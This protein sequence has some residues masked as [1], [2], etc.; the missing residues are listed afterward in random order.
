MVVRIVTSLDAVALSNK[1]ISSEPAD[2]ITKSGGC[3]SIMMLTA[4]T[5]FHQMIKDHMCNTVHV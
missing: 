1:L 2:S 3:L 5:I 4:P